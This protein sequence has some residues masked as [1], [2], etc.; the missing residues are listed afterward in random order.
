MKYNVSY[1]ATNDVMF[2]AQ[3]AEGFRAGGTNEPSIEPL[4]ECQGF[5]GYGSD[6][7]WNYE[8]GMKSSWLNRSLTVNFTP[9]LSTGA[10]CR[11]A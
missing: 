4:P 1:D 10:T 11:F 3:A 7:L 6:S 2:Y 8:V 5:E 9:Y